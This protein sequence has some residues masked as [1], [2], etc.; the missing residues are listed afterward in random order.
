M[1]LEAYPLGIETLLHGATVSP[2]SLRERGIEE[3]Y[4]FSRLENQSSEHYSISLASMRS[5]A[6]KQGVEIFE[7]PTY[8]SSEG[9]IESLR[10]IQQSEDGT[11]QAYASFAGDG[12][13]NSFL[14]AIR[15]MGGQRALLFAGGNKNDLPNQTNTKATNRHPE[16]LLKKN[17]VRFLHPLEVK[18]ETGNEIM[19]LDAFGYFSAGITANIA[20]QLNSADFKDNFLHRSKTGQLLHEYLTAARGILRAPG[21][22]TTKN[23]TPEQ[24]A[25]ILFANGRLMAG[26]LRPKAELFNRRARVIDAAHLLGALGIGAALRIGLPIGRDFDG[27]TEF[28]LEGPKGVWLQYDGESMWRDSATVSVRMADQPVA[29]LSAPR[30]A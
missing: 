4:V 30:A 8:P 26:A 14:T 9:F 10:S 21:F 27:Q 25:E 11:K 24:T 16:R 13:T 22:T 5:E 23:G 17:V 29:I 12:T 6:D 3:L 20:H 2:Q 18:I 19:E 28:K 1:S 15:K 7:R